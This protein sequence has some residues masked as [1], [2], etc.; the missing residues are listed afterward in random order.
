ML[1]ISYAFGGNSIY[2]PERCFTSFKTLKIND[3]W[4]VNFHLAGAIYPKVDHFLLIS[5]PQASCTEL[6]LI[7]LWTLSAKDRGATESPVK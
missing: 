2:R 3:Y 1:K 5:T 4:E 6:T 7:E